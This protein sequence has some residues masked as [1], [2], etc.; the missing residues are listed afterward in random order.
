MPDFIPASLSRTIYFI[1][2]SLLLY[3]FTKISTK[4]SR[5]K[6]MIL[7]VLQN[8]MK[9]RLKEGGSTRGR[10]REREELVT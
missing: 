8:G 3:C 6:I 9:K 7:L 10:E 4:N 5:I 1:I 2:H